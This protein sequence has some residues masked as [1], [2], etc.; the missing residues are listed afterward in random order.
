MAMSLGV[1]T[2]HLVFPS[3]G[4]Y[5][6]KF[7]VLLSEIIHKLPDKRLEIKSEYDFVHFQKVSLN[8]F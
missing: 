3:V 7:P 6:C 4:A 5:S 2:V 1:S 8:S